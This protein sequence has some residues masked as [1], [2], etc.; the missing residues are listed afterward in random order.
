MEIAKEVIG[1][2]AEVLNRKV[3]E[4]KVED[5]LELDELDSVE[6]CLAIEEKFG[7]VIPDEVPEK[8]VTLQ[9]II[10]YVGEE[11]NKESGVK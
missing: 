10:N 8:F 7:I 1:I 2:V 6:I 5:K 4:L 3:E 11:V 9:D